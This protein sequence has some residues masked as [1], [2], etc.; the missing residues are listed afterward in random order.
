MKTPFV[1]TIACS[2]G[3]VGKSTLAYNIAVEL[4][5]K[6]ETQVIDL[7]Y[8]K[9]ISIFNYNR[10]KSNLAKLNIAPIIKNEK[11]L[12]QII[13]ENDGLIIIDTGAFDSDI[14]RAALLL[15]N[16]I[17]VPTS[18]S[19]VDLYGLILFKKVLENI[20][21]AKKV[22]AFLILNKIITRSINKSTVSSFMKE[23]KNFFKLFKNSMTYRLDYKKS[24][25][26]GKSVCEIPKSKAGI[27]IKK[28]IKEIE[29]NA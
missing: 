16:M 6:Y 14:N 15:S 19:Q 26:A 1:L 7:D 22:K 24:F 8:Q 23:H 13:K 21:L 3:G 27:E 11:Q 28:V 9:S 25:E 2:K 4:S 20:N 10:E 29:E 17:I 12:R 18:D 5:K